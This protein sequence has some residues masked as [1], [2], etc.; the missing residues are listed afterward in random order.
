MEKTHVKFWGAPGTGKTTRLLTVTND[1]L[2]GDYTL[3][4]FVF[5]TFS[6]KM[7]EDFLQKMYEKFNLGFYSKKDALERFRYFSTIHGVCNRL[8][9][10]FLSFKGVASE[11][12]KE[13]FCKLHHYEFDLNEANTESF[14]NKFFQTKSW[15]TNTFR[16]LRDCKRWFGS[17]NPLSEDVYASVLQKWEKYK[18]ENLLRDFDDMI[19]HVFEKRLSPNKRVLIVDEFQD[20]SPLQYEVYKIWRDSHERVYIAGDPNQSIYEFQGASPDFFMKEDFVLE[21][22]PFSYRFGHHSWD[23]AKQILEDYGLDVPEVEPRGEDFPI[24]SISLDSLTSFINPMESTFILANTNKM[25][26]NIQIIL[27]ESGI[28]FTGLGGWRDNIIALYNTLL[29]FKRR[30]GFVTTND[31]REFLK[32]L[33]ADYIQGRKKDLSSLVLPERIYYNDVDKYLSWFMKESIT[34]N[35]LDF[36][37]FNASVFSPSKKDSEESSKSRKE[38]KIKNALL[39][40]NAWFVSNN[41][42]VHTTTIHGSKGRERDNVFVLNSLSKP[43]YEKL[44]TE[45]DE[46]ARLF[47]VA[48]TR[49]RKRLFIISDLS[50]ERVFSFPSTI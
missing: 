26:R 2:T 30:D 21:V 42:N 16:P 48:C 39:R 44:F 18:S 47:Y 4:D 9:N 3:D 1:L 33:K 5:C 50:S 20:L 6:I 29:M 46:I 31:F 27:E 36:S 41:I 24:R 25:V 37:I 12:Q 34:Q 8:C 14:G 7:A 40:S 49:Q 35:P 38:I 22:L 17:E 13:K 28:P 23:F 10:D 19:L 43:A 11:T 32:S 15:L 45:P